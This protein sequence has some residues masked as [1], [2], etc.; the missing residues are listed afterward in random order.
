MKIITIT[1]SNDNGRPSLGFFHS[2]GVTPEMAASACKAVAAE[3]DKAA[4]EAEVQRRLEAAKEKPEP[5]AKTD[6]GSD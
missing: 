2:D 3:Y 4:I 6:D 1:L 5:E